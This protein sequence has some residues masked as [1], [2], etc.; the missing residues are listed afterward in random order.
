MLDIKEIKYIKVA[1]ELMEEILSGKFKAGEKLYS[2]AQIASKYGIGTA[3]AVRVQDYLA[4]RGYVRKVHGSG[5]FVNYD[6]DSL[7]MKMEQRKYQNINRIIELRWHNTD[8]EN[9]CKGF[10]E[11]INAKIQQVKIGYEQ[12]LFGLSEISENAIN[13]LPLDPNAGY[14]IVASGPLSIRYT[15]SAL[16]NPNIHNVLID[17]LLPGT[18]C[19]LSDSFDGMEKLV[20]YAIESHCKHFIFAK[21]F[22][23]HLGDVYNEERCYAGVYHC[24]RH[25]HDCTVIDSGSYDE[26]IEAINSSR[27]KTCVMF[28]QDEAA[29][30][31]KK[32]IK[33]DKKRDV[34]VTGFDDFPGF[35]KPTETIATI[36]I[37][38]SQMVDTAIDILTAPHVFRKK[39]V[40]IPGK[41][42][43]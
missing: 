19:V 22:V 28:P 36:R 3:T 43:V 34:I 32:L 40:R 24:R 30:R 27:Q 14:L 5:I 23:S 29:Y 26:L 10:Y 6:K 25:G 20:D 1:E 16:I 35:E 9:F 37:D 13:T 8:K 12:K 11:A 38:K 21:N 17:N 42:L 4:H 18:N 33:S 2:R 41:F 15:I 31:L 39:I 7:P